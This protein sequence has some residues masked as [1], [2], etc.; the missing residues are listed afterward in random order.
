MGMT[1][2]LAKQI[3]EKRYAPLELVYPELEGKLPELSVNNTNGL[4]L[5][6]LVRPES[7]NDEYIGHLTFEEVLM[8][9]V[10]SASVPE[11]AHYKQRLEKIYVAGK[12]QANEAEF[13]TFG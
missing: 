8:M 10:R 5:I 4:K 13:V 7:P 1:F 2:S 12:E 11:L 9:A 6:R 3:G